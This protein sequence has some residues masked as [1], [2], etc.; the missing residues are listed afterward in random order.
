MEEQTR[1][2]RVNSFGTYLRTLQTESPSKDPQVKLLK[3]LVRGPKLLHE[4]HT[5]SAL[6]LPDFL[7]TLKKLQDLHLVQVTSETRGELARLT[8][9]GAEVAVKAE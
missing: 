3:L 6:D 8:T 5:E 4:L 1:Q 2:T 7:S 9:T